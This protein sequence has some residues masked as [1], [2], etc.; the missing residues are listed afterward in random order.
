MITR[1][2]DQASLTTPGFA[3]RRLGDRDDTIGPPRRE[4]LLEPPGEPPAWMG[5]TSSGCESGSVS[6]IVT[7]T[8]ATFQTGKKLYVAGK[9]IRS[10]SDRA[11]ARPMASMSRNRRRPRAEAARLGASRTASTTMRSKRGGTSY[12]GRRRPI[13]EDGESVLSGL[14]GQRSE[15]LPGKSAKSPPIRQT[16]PVESNFHEQPRVRIPAASPGLASYLD[17]ALQRGSRRAHL[18]PAGGG[19]EPVPASVRSCG[20]SPIESSPRRRR[21]Q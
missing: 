13:D 20:L 5:N 11:T 4:R 21:C 14:P 2:R 18:A 9:Y 19:I 3:A 6:C 15:Q 12:R 10:I 7:T 1:I 8:F 16:A 17:R